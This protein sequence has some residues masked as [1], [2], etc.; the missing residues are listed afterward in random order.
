MTK[1][2]KVQVCSRCVVDA[3][4]SGV[5]F[6][7]NGVCSYCHM[8]DKLEKHYALN[9]KNKQKFDQLIA[10]MKRLGKNQRYDCIVALSGG[11][12][13]TYSLYLA[14]K[15]GLRPLAVN[16]DNGWISDVAKENINKALKILDVDLRT[17]SYEWEDLK[18]LYVAGLKASTPD[19][20]LC[21]M[22]GIF[23]ALYKTACAEGI[24]YIILGTSFRTEGIAPLK[25]RCIDGK[26][27]D[28]VARKFGKGKVRGF[29]KLRISNIL[30]Y[31]FIKN[32]KT[33][34]FPLYVEYHNDDISR[35]LENELG[36]V[37]GGEHHFDCLFHPLM[38]HL[39][40]EKF[41]AD[42]RKVD[43]S[44]LIRSDQMKRTDALQE[45]S[46]Q[47]SG[48]E[49][50]IKYCIEKLEL[51]EEEYRQILAAQPKDFTYYANY[52]S[53]IRRFRIVI[54]LL[55]KLH[56]LPETAYEKYFECD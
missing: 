30:F 53:I 4:V 35:R 42:K 29:N 10:K 14:K 44:A 45:L 16:F 21:C 31:S 12:D 18:A 50:G 6:D 26:Y 27:F 43:F 40:V 13:S 9:S 51:S 41:N 36:W 5:R 49:E 23:S 52:Y 47:P 11:M 38:H 56:I 55:C 7:D 1:E 15:F 24:K 34:Q 8:H 19:I 37:Y 33:V 3:T 20:C 25:W 28:D 22:I 48:H 2:T 32:I 54:K 17:V 39:R 46:K